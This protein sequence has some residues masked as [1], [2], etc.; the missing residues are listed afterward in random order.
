[1]AW[2]QDFLLKF[3]LCKLEKRLYNLNIKDQ[4]RQA[5]PS[6]PKIIFQTSFVQFV[7]ICITI[8]QVDLGST[9]AAAWKCSVKNELFLEKLQVTTRA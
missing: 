1:M 6:P 2:Q 7:S 5:P 8:H 4:W 3:L 9:E